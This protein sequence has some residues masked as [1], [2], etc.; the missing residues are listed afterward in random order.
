MQAP[1]RDD[2]AF[3]GKIATCDPPR[4]ISDCTV[5]VRS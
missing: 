3:T 1:P 4:A 2:L 5:D